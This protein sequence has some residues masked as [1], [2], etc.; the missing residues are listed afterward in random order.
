MQIYQ[1]KTSINCSNCVRSVSGFLNELETVSHWEVDTDHPDKILT[2][3]SKEENSKAIV[4]AVEDAGFDI[5]LL[6]H[7]EA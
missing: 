5:E 2:V 3:K 4:D 7:Q 1:F 6:K